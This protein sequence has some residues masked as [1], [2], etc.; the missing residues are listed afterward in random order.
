MLP[1]CATRGRFS[2]G[3][4]ECDYRDNGEGTVHH[5]RT[6]GGVNRTLD[7]CLH[8]DAGGVVE[9]LARGRKTINT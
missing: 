7:P 9:N 5:A 1:A 3:A 2:P 6:D 4:H 8:E